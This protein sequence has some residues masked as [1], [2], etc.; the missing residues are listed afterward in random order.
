MH[1]RSERRC[2]NR[3]GG[4]RWGVVPSLRTGRCYMD[5]EN[6]ADELI[7]RS[8]TQNGVAPR[9]VQALIALE[10]DFANFSVVGSK[11]EFLRQVSQILDEAACQPE[12]QAEL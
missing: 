1:V 10:S 8:A 9:V 7:A 2:H 6:N 4:Y 5:D 3:K 12:A 11:A